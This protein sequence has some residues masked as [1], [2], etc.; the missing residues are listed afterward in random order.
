MDG[1]RKI[2]WPVRKARTHLEANLF[3]PH[4]STYMVTESTLGL[5][6]LWIS[7]TYRAIHKSMQGK[8]SHNK[9]TICATT[10]LLPDPTDRRALWTLTG[11]PP[12]FH[13]QLNGEP[14]ELQACLRSDTCS[15]RARPQQKLA[16]VPY[17][18]PDKVMTIPCLGQ[19]MQGW[20]GTT[21]PFLLIIIMRHE[22][23]VYTKTPLQQLQPS[24]LQHIAG[25]W[26]HARQAGKFC[27]K[28]APQPCRETQ[29][30]QP[31]R[32]SSKIASTQRV[33]SQG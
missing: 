4:S 1:S 28:S 16:M 27:G 31:T 7:F 30:A 10:D 17:L 13:Q 32:R 20:P 26:A 33:L 22:G 11:G 25:S 29:P 24:E 8:Q 9:Q 14:V 2:C 12:D 21:W 19:L 3:R 23:H 5:R 6:S 18:G 15:S